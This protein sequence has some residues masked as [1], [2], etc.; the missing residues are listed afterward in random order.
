MTRR[1]DGEE[2]EVNKNVR[3]RG[4][5]VLKKLNVEG[6]GGWSLENLMFGDGGLKKTNVEGRRGS[7]DIKWVGDV[8]RGVKNLQPTTGHLKWNGP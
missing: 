6:R 1:G 8:G 5:G 3:S 4:G 2:P 7:S